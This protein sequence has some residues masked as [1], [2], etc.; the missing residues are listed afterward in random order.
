MDGWMGGWVD[1]GMSLKKSQT[2][3]SGFYIL[4]LFLFLAEVVVLKL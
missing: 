2:S 4:F 3:L 1:V